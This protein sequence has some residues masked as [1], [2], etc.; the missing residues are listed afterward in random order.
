MTSPIASTTCGAGTF[1]RTF[2]LMTIAQLSQVLAPS[3]GSRGIGASLNLSTTASSYCSFETMRR[4]A[5]WP[6]FFER[7]AER[8][9][10]TSTGS[11]LWYGVKS[12]V[13]W[14]S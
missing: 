9:P 7:S 10:A 14:P 1:S 13:R 6:L 12:N 11:P 2:P 3:I 8:S 5:Q 4:P